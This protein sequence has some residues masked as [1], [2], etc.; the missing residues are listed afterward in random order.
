MDDGRFA[1]AIGYSQGAGSQAR[2]RSDVDDTAPPV[3]EHDLG[4]SL[5]APKGA[6]Q[7]GVHDVTPILPSHFQ[8]R[9]ENRNARVVDQSVDAAELF[10]DA[11][12]GPRHLVGLGD[13][14]VNRQEIGAVEMALR[15]DQ[16]FFVTVQSR[17][18][19]TALEES[20]ANLKANTASA[21][22]DDHNR[23]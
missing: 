10:L 1:G 9:F 5:R 6:V 19:V 13:I 17:D 20:V 15:F 11:I 7:I 23:V 3:F 4:T 18:S 21:S 16:R 8:Y 14:T 12:D 22:G 2:D